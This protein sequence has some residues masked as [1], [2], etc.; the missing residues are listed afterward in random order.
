MKTDI[1]DGFAKEF[2]AYLTCL[3]ETVRAIRD[4]DWTSGLKPRATPVHQVCHVLSAILRYAHADDGR[5]DIVIGWK[6]QSQYPSR[7][8]ILEIIDCSRQDVARYVADVADRTLA[9]REW[10]VPP[11]HK[12]IYLLRHSVW[13][14]CCLGE[15]LRGRGY[16]M[17]TYRK[18]LRR[19]ESPP[20]AEKSPS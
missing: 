9:D 11:L 7:Q 14:L 16:R 4:E 19:R 18:S 15:E 3:T 1:A 2:D 12:L 10:S 13:H 17:P 5:A 6:P 20:S 8:R